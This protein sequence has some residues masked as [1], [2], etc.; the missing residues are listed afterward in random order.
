MGGQ[1]HSTFA[2]KNGVGVFTG[3]C[4]IVPSLKAPGFC[5]AEAPK[6]QAVDGSQHNTFQITLK[7]K[8]TLTA[9]KSSWTGKHVPKDPDCHHPG[10]LFEQGIY[11]VR[12]DECAVL[13]STVLHMLY[14]L[15]FFSRITFN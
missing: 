5:D 14:E 10:C 9:F 7:N 13:H 12:S 8:G 3:D 6:F 1:S 15:L 2:V 11:K 4:K